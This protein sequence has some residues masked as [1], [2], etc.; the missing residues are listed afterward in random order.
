MLRTMDLIL[1]LPPMSQYDAAAM[2]MYRCF[3]N[4]PDPTPY[5]VKPELVNLKEVNMAM[6]KWQRRSEEFDFRKEDLA[7]EAE[8]NEII[9]VAAKGENIPCPAPKHAAFINVVDEE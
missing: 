2:P 5:K 7:P 3:S 6:N 9:W 8:L 1:G 4:T